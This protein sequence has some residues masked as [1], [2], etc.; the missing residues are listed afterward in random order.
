MHLRPQAIGIVERQRTVLILFDFDQVRRLGRHPVRRI[1]GNNI[2]G[3]C[4]GLHCGAFRI[5]HAGSIRIRAEM[6]PH[7]RHQRIGIGL[8]THIGE[9]HTV[10]HQE[11]TPVIRITHLPHIYQIDPFVRRNF[12]DNGVVFIKGCGE[13][14]LV[15]SLIGRGITRT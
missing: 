8:L 9:V 7:K 11:I 2:L 14:V 6:L 3:P 13:S 4:T 15:I 5:F 12:T 10:G 1:K